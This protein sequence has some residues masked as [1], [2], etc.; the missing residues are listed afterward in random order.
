MV[1]GMIDIP[2]DD[3][4]PEI[5]ITEP[6]KPEEPRKSVHFTGIDGGNSSGG[7]DR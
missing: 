1:H 6:K 3:T 5:Q 4:L 7:E 2:E